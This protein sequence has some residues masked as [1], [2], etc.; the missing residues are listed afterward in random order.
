[1]YLLDT[2]ICIYT[3]NKKPIEVLKKLKLKSSKDIYI[4]SITIAELEHGVEKSNF[5]ERNKVALVEFMSL[6]QILYYTDSD[7]SFYGKIRSD[8]EKRGKIIGTMDML[9]ASQA[10]SHNLILVTN[11]VKEFERIENIKIENWTK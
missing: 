3:I 4:S 5:P 1:M 9:I 11:N 2:N 8:L 6:F 10:L 7:A